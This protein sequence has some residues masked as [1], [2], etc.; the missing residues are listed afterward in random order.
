[1]SAR[2]RQHSENSEVIAELLLSLLLCNQRVE[3]NVLEDVQHLIISIPSFPNDC[4]YF[5]SIEFTYLYCV[6]Q[7]ICQN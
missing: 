3:E 5:Q 2:F 6:V 4:Q 1:M 7:R